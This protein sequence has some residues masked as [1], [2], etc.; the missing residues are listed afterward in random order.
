MLQTTKAN[1]ANESFALKKLKGI[2]PKGVK[3][4]YTTPLEL[5][6]KAGNKLINDIKSRELSHLVDCINV[7]PE[8]NQAYL[9]VKDF[10]DHNLPDLDFTV[11]DLKSYILAHS[12]VDLPSRNAPLGLYTG[13]LLSLLC[14]QNKEKGERTIFCMDGQGEY[15]PYLFFL[16]NQVDVLALNNWKGDCICRGVAGFGGQANMVIGSN[17]ESIDGFRDMGCEGGSSGLV[18]AK[19]G[20][21]TVDI[22]LN[23]LLAVSSGYSDLL[24]VDN[25]KGI[26][27]AGKED[28][29]PA[30]K[31]LWTSSA[32]E[33][34]DLSTEKYIELITVARKD[35]ETNHLKNITF[36]DKY[37]PEQVEN[38]KKNFKVREMLN[39][40]DKLNSEPENKQVETVL[41][42]EKI[43]KEVKYLE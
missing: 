21:Q 9:R 36:V 12:K 13:V 7:V 40:V 17:L 29:N 37:Y 22:W 11:D 25:F 33:Q 39:L 38:Y 28:N 18:I 43:Y 30:T 2:K 32:A 19:E 6:T 24:I 8:F 5:I 4:K 26:L 35:L 41:Q 10:V 16:A 15:F 31:F 3:T 42:L 27:F 14:M 20:N 1:Q 23:S 34:S